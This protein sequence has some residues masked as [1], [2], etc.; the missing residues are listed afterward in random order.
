[1]TKVVCVQ[2]PPAP[3]SPPVCST[4]H[5]P[6]K[7]IRFYYYCHLF[8]IIKTD[9]GRPAGLRTLLF[10]DSSVFYQLLA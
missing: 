7:L 3:G 2:Y 9:N 10:G 6:R 4:L 5:N 8:Q 1:M